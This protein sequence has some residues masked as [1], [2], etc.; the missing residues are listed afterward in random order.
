MALF[1]LQNLIL[2]SPPSSHAIFHVYYLLPSVKRQKVPE[3]E[4]EEK[5]RQMLTAAN[6]DHQH[7]Q[8]LQ[9]RDS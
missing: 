6:L 1:L 7:I 4:E 3:E 2:F 8:L 5:A 9:K